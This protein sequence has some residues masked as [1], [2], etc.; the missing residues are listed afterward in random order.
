MG[1]FDAEGEGVGLDAL[2]NAFAQVLKMYP[3]G[4]GDGA[5][6]VPVLQGGGIVAGALA[7]Q[8]GV[9]FANAFGDAG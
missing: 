6:M 9:E 7:I 2:P 4:L 1:E 5:V 3:T 8:A